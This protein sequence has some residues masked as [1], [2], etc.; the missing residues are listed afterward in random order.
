MEFTTEFCTKHYPRAP[1]LE[2]S[3]D[4]KNCWDSDSSWQVSRRKL[5]TSEQF[6]AI[7]F[8]KKR[9]FI[10]IGFKSE[11]LDRASGR[12]LLKSLPRSNETLEYFEL[13]DIIQMCCHVVWTTCRD[14]LK[15]MIDLASGRCCSDVRTSSMFICKTLRGVQT[16]SKVRPDDWTWYARLALW[17]TSSGR[18]H[19]SFGRL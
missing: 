1:Y 6:S 10:F 19:T 5:A 15:R 16:P 7:S 13:L 17:R 18:D 2:A 3:R 8:Q 9:N 4:L 12:S 11:W 14:F